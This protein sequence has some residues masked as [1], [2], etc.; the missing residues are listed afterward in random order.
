MI[1]EFIIHCGTK[2]SVYL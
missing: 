2:L 1:G